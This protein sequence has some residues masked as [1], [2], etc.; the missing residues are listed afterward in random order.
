MKLPCGRRPPLL[1]LRP[2]AKPSGAERELRTDDARPGTRAMTGV[3]RGCYT[4]VQVLLERLS[5]AMKVVLQEQPLDPMDFLIRQLQAARAADEEEVEKRSSSRYQKKIELP[6][7]DHRNNQDMWKYQAVPEEKKKPEATMSSR[8]RSPEPVMSAGSARRQDRERWWPEETTAK[9]AEVQEDKQK[10]QV[11]QPK[12]KSGISKKTKALHD[13]WFD[14][15]NDAF[16]ADCD[17]RRTRIND[18]L[19]QMPET[20]KNDRGCMLEAVKIDSDAFKYADI[21][22]KADKQFVLDMLQI[23]G[24][25]FL[26]AHDD[27]KADRDV[28]LAAVQIDGESLKYAH[29]DLRADAEIVFYA[30][31]VAGMA[32]KYANAYLRSDEQIVLEAVASNFH[33][34]EYADTRLKSN[35]DF[36][37]E[38]VR[39]HGNSFKYADWSLR[40]DKKFVYGIVS[41]KGDALQFASDELRADRDVVLAAVQRS[42]GALRYAIGDLDQDEDIL[43]AADSTD[44]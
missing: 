44:D 18:V 15:F 37:R 3:P 39:A 21:S 10:F 7:I 11:V 22:L 30:V 2:E 23:E 26:H 4:S 29:I 5:E 6:S 19:A 16:L 34:M 32:I 20:I 27:L 12:Q 9:A 40:S 28:V 1:P 42:P 33:A 43:D 14:E 31:Q 25:S 41:I 35:R 38:A 24:D 36:V 13:R 8:K 17:V